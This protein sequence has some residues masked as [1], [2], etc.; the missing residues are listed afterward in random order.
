MIKVSPELQTKIFEAVLYGRISN[1]AITDYY[2]KS[3]T[4]T[5]IKI[6][7][8]LGRFYKEIY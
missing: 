5:D 6:N 1:F 7:K 4:D 8:M 2:K 3:K